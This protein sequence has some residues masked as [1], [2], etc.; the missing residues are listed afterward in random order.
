MLVAHLF[1][2]FHEACCQPAII[3][4]QEAHVSLRRFVDYPCVAPAEGKRM[5]PA[6]HMRI[7]NV[8]GKWVLCMRMG[9]VD[10]ERVS[11]AD[12][13][14]LVVRVDESGVVCTVKNGVQW[15]L[16]VIGEPLPGVAY[17]WH[18]CVCVCE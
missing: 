9:C 12:S 10:G 11:H 14:R 4:V 6:R 3:T 18:M 8:D 16:S 1:I 2:A 7:R 15:M 13:R 17:L 5:N